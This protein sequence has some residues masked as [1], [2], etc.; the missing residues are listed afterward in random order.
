MKLNME[1]GSLVSEA[2]LYGQDILE[3]AMFSEYV[4]NCL[5]RH[6]YRTVGHLAR[7]TAQELLTI[8]GIREPQCSEIVNTLAKLGVMIPE[9]RENPPSLIYDTAR[10]LPY[11]QNLIYDI[12]G[13][14]TYG[15][16]IEKLM[17]PDH[18]RGLAVALA[19]LSDQDE[20][21]LLLRYKHLYSY[22][23]VGKHYQLTKERARQIIREALRK[24]RHPSQ[25]KLIAFGLNR[26]IEDRAAHEAQIISEHL[27]YDEYIRGYRDGIEDTPEKHQEFCQNQALLPMPIE[28]LCLSV[29]SYNCLKRAGINTVNDIC[30]ADTDQILHIRNLGMK[31]TEEIAKKLREKGL[32]ATAWDKAIE[33]RRATWGKLV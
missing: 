15:R 24:L 23:E 6:G 18:I 29:R 12:F 8:K 10:K 3:T 7:M 11:P 4:R 17:G 13:G 26:Y 30:A 14:E 21:M 5:Y 28:N 32:L 9:Y 31:S 20:T 16:D 1:M 19:M 22:E 25:S 33:K 2:R 27:L